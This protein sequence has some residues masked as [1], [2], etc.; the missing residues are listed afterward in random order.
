[1]AKPICQGQLYNPQV[2]KVSIKEGLSDR[3]VNHVYQDA[4]GFVWLGCNYGLNRYDG[5]EIKIYTKENH[6]L[7]SNR[8]I[9]VFPLN[10][11]VMILNHQIQLDVEKG[12]YQTQFS[13]FN[14]IKEKALPFEVLFE[15]IKDIN[16]DNIQFIGD[17][18]LID[19]DNQVYGMVESNNRIRLIKKGKLP[20]PIKNAHKSTQLAGRWWVMCRD[21]ISQKGI[22]YCLDKNGISKGSPVLESLENPM[23]VYVGLYE[24]S[25]G[26]FYYSGKFDKDEVHEGDFEF[27]KCDKS[28]NST[29]FSLNSEGKALNYQ[30][31]NDARL[32]FLEALGIC[33]VPIDQRF[34]IFDWEGNLIAQT[35]VLMPNLDILST[36]VDDHNRI[37]VLGADGAYVVALQAELF[38]KHLSSSQVDP[39]STPGDQGF[40]MRA[41]TEDAEGALWFCVENKEPLWKINHEGKAVTVASFTEAQKDF[42]LDGKFTANFAI[43]KDKKG[44]LWMTDDHYSLFRMDP[45]TEELER[46][47]YPECKNGTYTAY[48]SGRPFAN[49]CILLDD[50]ADKVWVGH[51]SGLSVLDKKKS[52][53]EEYKVP[54]LEGIREVSWFHQNEM[55]IWIAAATGLYLLKPETGAIEHFHAKGDSLHYLPH[56]AFVHIYE[57]S[58]GTFWMASNQG[59]GLLR[60]NPTTKVFK[61]YTVNEGLSHN[62][63]YAVYEDNY[64]DLWMSS[65]AG[66][67]RFNKERETVDVYL[68][69]DGIPHIE[70][71]TMSHFQAKDGR[72][73]FGGLNG[74]VEFHPKDFH[75]EED[76]HQAQLQIVKY[77]VLDRVSGNYIDATSSLV[78]RPSIH[79]SGN[80]QSFILEFALLD[81]LAPEQNSY[82]YKIEGMDAAWHYINGN[83][84]RIGN[85]PYGS[86]T[87]KV[88][89]RGIGGQW[90][91]NELHIPLQVPMP[92]YKS[93]WFI[94]LMILVGVLII[95]SYVRWRI[96]RLQEAK[97]NLEEEVKKRTKKIAQQAEEL[98]ALDRVKSRFFANVSHELRTPLTLILGPLRRL[99]GK[100][101]LNYEIASPQLQVMERNSEQ[102]LGLVE[103]ILDLSKLEASKLEM[104]ETVVSFH[105]YISRIFYSFEASAA[106]KKIQLEL[107]N[108]ASVQLYLLLDENKVEKIFNNLLSNAMKF[109]PVNGKIYLSVVELEDSL[110]IRVKDTGEGIHEA[111]LPNIFDRFYQSKQ[112][113][114]KAQGGTGIGLALAKELTTLIGGDLSVES[115]FGEGATF[116]FKLPKKTASKEDFLILE[117]KLEKSETSFELVFPNIVVDATTT[118]LIV[119]DHSDMRAFIESIVGEYYTTICVGN[120][121]EALD[122]LGKTTSRID[123]II[124]D[125]M[126]PIMDGFQLLNTLKSS[127]NYRHLPVVMLT[128]RVALE[129]KLHALRIGVDDYLTKPFIAEELMVRCHNLLKNY[130]ERQAWSIK[131]A[132]EKV[133]KLEQEFR[134]EEAVSSQEKT[135]PSM[136]LEDQAWLMELERIV[137]KDCGNN[138]FTVEWLGG[139]LAISVRNLQRRIKKLTG[140]TPKKY[141]TEVRLQRA[142]E[143]FENRTYNTIA[144]VMHQ[145]GFQKQDHFS[146]LF[147]ER[148]GIHPKSF[149]I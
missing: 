98:K 88:K 90:S 124:S 144:Q 111:D 64:G 133:A 117:T 38:K 149:K 79:L 33:V 57:D 110:Q 52:Y 121:E 70:F 46:F 14:P 13:L 107:K 91:K 6:Q 129:D 55:G 142:R 8:M 1:L 76:A 106:Y 26:N 12:C 68:P 47:T 120:G 53:L 36:T 84:I 134:I 59:G 131:D 87:L 83:N 146:K 99:L 34:D 72:I 67:M 92:F 93:L 97:D 140:L 123:L 50:N 119:E 108:E 51:I 27:F 130:R 100:K 69:K 44:Q 60:W 125:V 81:Y 138:N 45:K 30:Q 23:Q 24:D 148:F 31:D 58:A 114:K 19:F 37:W 17:G 127:D 102:L 105:A 136:S 61:K 20:G 2:R 7:R 71:N 28:G 32:I 104:N 21:S 95:G 63:I 112:E 62:V 73:V 18:I 35:D 4:R 113:G 22:I 40:A 56:S 10:D 9:G 103:E 48:N 139:A 3:F 5:N 43:Q 96:Q 54:G 29:V 85:L 66:I 39:Y 115:T 145:V 74:A 101:E 137:K 11:S 141:I 75:S 128:A 15:P 82:A 77:S 147:I 122:V 89:G 135:V 78:L 118:V 116:Y 94:F 143:L 109:T 25:L 65:N 86:Y 132:K 126:M 41:I 49:R 42:F 16:V 80:F